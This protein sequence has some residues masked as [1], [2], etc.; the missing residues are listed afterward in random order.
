MTILSYIFLPNYLFLIS[1]TIASVVFAKSK[2][3]DSVTTNLIQN[4]AQSGFEHFSL[5][6]F[7]NNFEYCISKIYYFQIDYLHNEKIFCSEI[8][9]ISRQIFNDDI[10]LLF[11][12][13]FIL[14][15]V[16]AVGSCEGWDCKWPSP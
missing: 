3:A 12:L 8:K 6:T 10:C 4:S 7:K 14:W 5:F 1:D 13:I 2:Q 15:F 11:Y 16:C 9:R